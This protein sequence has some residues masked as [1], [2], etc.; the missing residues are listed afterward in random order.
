MGKN[1]VQK[2]MEDL[3]VSPTLSPGSEGGI[4]IGHALTPDITG[5]MA[6]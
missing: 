1:S 4:S 5:T 2:I 3:L 6:L